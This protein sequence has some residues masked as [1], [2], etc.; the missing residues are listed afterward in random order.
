MAVIGKMDREKGDRNAEKQESLI[1]SGI[2][3]RY[4]RAI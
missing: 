4:L 1:F 3:L 2:M